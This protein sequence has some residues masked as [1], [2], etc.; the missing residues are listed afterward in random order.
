MHDLITVPPP[1]LLTT[2]LA[3]VGAPKGGVALNSGAN[4]FSLG[5]DG[6]PPTSPC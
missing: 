6:T 1:G 5:V 3:A 4:D 2:E